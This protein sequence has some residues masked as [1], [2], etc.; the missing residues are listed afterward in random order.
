LTNAKKWHD[1]WEEFST[2]LLALVPL[3]ANTWYE[4]LLLGDVPVYFTLVRAI[5]PA[6]VLM[7]EKISDRVLSCGRGEAPSELLFC[8]EY[9]ETV[10]EIL[11]QAN[12]LKLLEEVNISGIT[13]VLVSRAVTVPAGVDE[14]NA[15]VLNAVFS[16]L[17]GL[18][19]RENDEY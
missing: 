19:A 5:N 1:L 13:G 4:R 8:L 2:G 10:D 3:G 11:S 6:A 14:N 15:A 7:G 17:E 18:F 12:L 9:L 16:S